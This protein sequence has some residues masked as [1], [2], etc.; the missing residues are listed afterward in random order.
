MA[1]NTMLSLNPD[2][3]SFVVIGLNEQD[4]LQSSLEAIQTFK[5]SRYIT[6]IFYVDSGS[7]DRSVEIAQSVSGV[8]ILYLTTPQK[9][10]ARARNVGLKRVTG[11]FV[12][13][14]DGDSVLQSGWLPCALRIMETR[15]DV[16]CV[17]GH[18]IEMH[19]DQ[20]IYMKLCGMDWHISPGEHR[21]CGGNALWRTSVLSEFGFFDEALRFGEEP[22]LCYR[23]RQCGWKILCIDVPMVTHDLGMRS[24]RDYWIRAENVGKGYA[25]IALRYW[26]FPEKL[27]LREALRNFVEPVIWVL[28]LS[29]GFQIGSFV[30]ALA[31]LIGWLFSRALQ[32]AV[33]TRK[34][35]S[36]F[37]FA[38][39]YGLHTQF[40]CL[41]SLFGQLKV[42][43]GS[44]QKP[45]TR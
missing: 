26:T 16:V 8:N 31:L 12:H 27:W 1:N 17:F 42:L 43:F 15:P 6:E 33:G 22:D 14:V 36:S 4:R 35:A 19:P 9:S 40:M 23:V 3:V 28:A 2:L 21:L 18:C 39:L 7:T 38:F 30:G 37:A 20:S 34:R 24:F 45:M 25:R 11:A 10:A 13:L 5:C 32:I 41:P 44:W 29:L